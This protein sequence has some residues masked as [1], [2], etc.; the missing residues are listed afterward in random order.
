MAK[1]NI[2]G[3]GN[4]PKANAVVERPDSEQTVRN[5]QQSHG[6][7]IP[8]G[9]GRSYGDSSLSAAILE[10]SKLTETLSFD[11]ETGIFTCQSGKMLNT[12]LDEIVPK[13]YFLPV[14]PGTK[15][16]TIGGAIAAD[17]HGKNH[18]VDGCFSQHVLWLKLMMAD[19]SVKKCSRTENT[20]LF[21]ATCGGMGLTG[22]IL[23]ASFQLKKI[24]TSKIVNRTIK[25]ENLDEVISNLL[26]HENYTYSVAW[27]DCG[28]SGK[29]LGRSLLYL[30]E[31]AKKEQVS[32]DDL[33]SYKTPSPIVSLPFNLPNWTL[34]KWTVKAFNA[35]Y[36]GKVRKKD[37]TAIVG[38]EPYFY[39]LDIA[40]NW[41]RLYGSNGFAQYQFVIPMEG[42]REGMNS[43]MQEI[44][45]SGESSFLAVL[46][47]FGEQNQG[48]LSFPKRGLQLALDF[49]IN[50]KSLELMNRLD[51]MVMAMDG[52][53]YLAKDSR[54]KREFFESSYPKLPRFKQLL[55]EIDPNGKFRSLQSDRL[56]ITTN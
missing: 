51:D 1:T 42:A 23:E 30:G 29:N 7:H 13:G 56:G 17:I 11:A 28:T 18:H 53:S 21:W 41:N 25:C 44:V 39:P 55:S 37:S 36:Y 9:A 54:M 15:F 38:F 27:I 33:S 8:R 52:R 12:I 20:E 45:K 49:P 31:H 6:I 34:N 50:K 2:S 3:W 32:N 46:K 10:S 43:I 22:F 5:L 16:I 47:L 4:F 14:T 40:N 24:E 26:E 48:W 19:G 35:L